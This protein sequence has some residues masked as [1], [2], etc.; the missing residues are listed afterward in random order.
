MTVQGRVMGIIS[1]QS[2]EQ[3]RA[4][5]QEQIDLLTIVANQAAI[6]LENHRLYVKA[7][8][9]QEVIADR[10][11]QL[12][13]STL[14]MDFIHKLN[15]LAGPI[16]PWVTLAKRRLGNLGITDAKLMEYFD[17]IH[18]QVPALILREAHEYRKPLA[19]SEEVDIEELLGSILG[20]I[21]LI[22]QP[23]G[24]TEVRFEIEPNLPHL[25]CPRRLLETAFFS[26][27]ENATKAV[28]GSGSIQVFGSLV[29]SS[30]SDES[31]LCVEVL[32]TGC[33]IPQDKLE[34]IFEQGTSYWS[35]SEGTGYG[36]W[37]A[38]SIVQ[39][40]WGFNNGEEQLARKWRHLYCHDT[41][42]WPH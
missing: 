32:I 31:Q 3:E 35:K 42:P 6:A 30:D 15:N 22:A 40:L 39:S 29:I 41:F 24:K 7:K 11:R 21:E 28:S 4:F 34:Q 14:A 25:F 19:E 10:E 20:Q 37:R 18:N 33:G 12:V 27:I 5:T 2:L 38:R 13:M 8:R 9:D 16:A 1:I 36:L 17:H 23:E 26:L